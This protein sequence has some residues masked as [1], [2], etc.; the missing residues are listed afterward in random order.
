M[1]QIPV[2]EAGAFIDAWSTF[3]FERI[4]QT[5]DLFAQRW[6]EFVLRGG[7][8]VILLRVAT[9]RNAGELIYLIYS[10]LL[11]TL[12]ALGH[13]MY[14]PQIIEELVF[15][16]CCGNPF[17][18]QFLRDHKCVTGSVPGKALA[19]DEY[20]EGLVRLIKTLMEGTQW[21]EEVYNTV[22]RNA[23]LL[24]EIRDH[25]WGALG[26]TQRKSHRSKRT[27]A[28]WEATM[29]RWFSE[30]LPWNVK[31]GRA[32]CLEPNDEK[33]LV[34]PEYKKARAQLGPEAVERAFDGI[35]AYLA[36]TPQPFAS[37]HENFDELLAEEAERDMQAQD[38]DVQNEQAEASESDDGE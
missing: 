16:W 13:N 6:A 19:K 36:A 34:K 15:A 26:I 38:E 25:M 4:D 11:E 2:P 23:M 31:P 9:R 18:V 17:W 29:L 28:M 21:S 1:K 12:F 10:D 24:R 22:T 37:S 30:T 3:M 27:H 8:Q 20:C 32:L 14:K 35:Q 7:M 33:L 5:D